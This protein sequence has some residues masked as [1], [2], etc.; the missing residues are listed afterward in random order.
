MEALLNAV[1]KHRRLILDAERY[2]WKHPETGYREIQTS[3]YMEDQ[4]EALGYE[5]VRAGDIP[6][7][8]TVL[9][10]GRTGPEVLIF[11]ELDSLICPSHPESDPNTGYVHACGHHAQ[12]AALLGI[13]AALKEHGV[14]DSLCGRIRLCAVPA[15]E[16]IEVGYR[17]ELKEKGI[18]KYF[19][20]KGEFLYRG[21]FDG[22]DMAFMV[23]TNKTFCSIKASVG[24]LIKTIHYKGLS[25]HA[26]ASPWSGKNALYAATQGLSA[27][28]ALRETFRESD[29]IR[30]HP[31]ITH[32]GEAVNAIPELVT[33]ESYV[34]GSSFEAMKNASKKINQALCGGAL[35][36]GGNI[37]IIDKP[38]YAPLKNDENMLL[39]A[40]DAAALAIPE[41]T[42]HVINDTSSGSTDMAELCGLM[43]V[44]HPYAGGSDGVD[45]GATYHIA[46]PEKA[47]V[48]SAKF[49]LGMLYLLL[50]DNAKRANEIIA[51]FKPAFSS[52]E[53]YFA[54]LDTFY[55]EG[56][57]ITYRDDGIAEIRL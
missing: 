3:K 46:D 18:I 7:F 22:V 45:H 26:G 16:L 39:L 25:A 6:G 43:P 41:E 56:D 33:V 54:Y 28:N 27:A 51:A 11:G 31:I 8:Y 49:Q 40:K 24:C 53:E 4:F 13:A 47:C 32:G 17:T 38:G 36:V 12:C 15:E 37:E 21:Y 5:L 30:F 34:R 52:K 14:C 9:D 57:R 19:G 55:S 1:D 48:K 50:S 44:V 2:I 20:G 42:F 35:S 10:T 29:I 23:H